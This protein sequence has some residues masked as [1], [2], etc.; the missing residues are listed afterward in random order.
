MRLLSWESGLYGLVEPFI[1]MATAEGW[2]GDLAVA[3]AEGTAENCSL[4]RGTDKFTFATIT[5]GCVWVRPL[6]VDE[7]GGVLRDSYGKQQKD[8]DLM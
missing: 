7:G 1:I 8:K 3:I 2:A 5:D 6:F 4:R